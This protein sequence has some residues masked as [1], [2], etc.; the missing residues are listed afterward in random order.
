[1]FNEICIN[2]E[3]LPI[4]IL[5]LLEK[6]LFGYSMHINLRDLF[7][8]K[9]NHVQEQWW[10]YFTYGCWSKRIHT[11]PESISPKVNLITQLEFE[12]TYLPFHS[13]A[14]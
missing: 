9:A 1:M 12:P 10:Y 4:Y 13:L 2:E 5:I 11:F 8:G 6:I 3:M 7:N 14:R